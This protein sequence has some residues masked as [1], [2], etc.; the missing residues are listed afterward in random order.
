M[1][2]YH[3]VSISTNVT[4]IFI[5]CKILEAMKSEWINLWYIHMVTYYSE[6]FLKR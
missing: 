4:N 1:F 3:C 5:I 6:I 2:L